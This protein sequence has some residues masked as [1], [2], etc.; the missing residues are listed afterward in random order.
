M[1]AKNAIHLSPAIKIDA[2]KYWRAIAAQVRLLLQRRR[3]R[4]ELARMTVFELKD[5]GLTPSDQR[6]LLRAPFW[7]CYPFADEDEAGSARRF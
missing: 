7:K 1:L 4:D 6:S 3:E 5:L 2:A